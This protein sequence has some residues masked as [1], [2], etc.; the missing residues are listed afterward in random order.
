MGMKDSGVKL[1]MGQHDL[2]ILGTIVWRIWLDFSGLPYFGHQYLKNTEFLKSV[3]HTPGPNP[4]SVSGQ[5]INCSEISNERAASRPKTRCD[6][7]WREQIARTH[8]SEALLFIWFH[9]LRTLL[10][11]A[12]VIRRYAPPGEKISLSSK[13]CRP[14]ASDLMTVTS[15]K[16]GEPTSG[17]HRKSAPPI[18]GFSLILGFKFEAHAHAYTIAADF[19]ASVSC[20]HLF[21]NFW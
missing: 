1:P 3:I 16:N 5:L 8:G 15:N 21:M 14:I 11:K 13:D 19:A 12:T 18:F 4:S 20:S 17:E 9:L 2:E 6:I 10:F 7:E